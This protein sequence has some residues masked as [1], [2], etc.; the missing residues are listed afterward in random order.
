MVTDD[1]VLASTGSDSA[2]P[3]GIIALV[4]IVGGIALM[5]SR[6]RS[7]SAVLAA[8]TVLVLGFAVSGIVMT[9][10]AANAAGPCSTPSASPSPIRTASPSPL[11]TVSPTPTPTVSPTPTPTVSPTPT[12]TPTVGPTPTPT[13][14]PTPTPTISPTPTPTSTLA[15][16]LTPNVIVP[17]RALQTAT[18]VVVEITNVGEAQ[19][20]GTIA[21]AVEMPGAPGFHTDFDPG[22]TTAQVDGAVYAVINDQVMISGTGTVTDP[23]RVIAAVVLAPGQTLRISFVVTPI[24]GNTGAPGVAAAVVDA[25]TGG[26]ETPVTNNSATATL[27]ADP[28]ACFVVNDKSL[29]RDTDA[30]GVVDRCDLDSDNDGILDTEEDVSHNGVFGDDDH[31]GDILILPVL[32]DGVPSYL[33]LDSENDGVL[34]LME[35]R[36]F[37]R[38]QIDAFDADHNGVFDATLS[39]GTNG[40]LDDLETAPDSGVL[41]SE[42]LLQRNLDGDSLPD[43]NDPMSDGSHLDLYE[44]GRAD[45]DQLGGGFITPIDDSDGDGIM[46]GADSGLAMRGSPG[47][48]YSPY[49]P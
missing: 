30:D 3:W 22:Q 1:C 45:L 24:E 37:T 8:G 5:V 29:T 16:D 2:L 7:R 35:G 31:D 15:P 36:P 49:Q 23:F 20:S 19:T 46:A 44:I 28:R 38:A 17:D 4:L 34:D 13:V 41:R 47:S 6:T 42:F 21:F 12:P 9:G 25:G 33:D 39:F 43:S 26:G 18:D 10:P 14:S 48:P 27:Q 32:G 40:L 11:P